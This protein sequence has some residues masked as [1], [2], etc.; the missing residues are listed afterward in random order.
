MTSRNELMIFFSRYLNCNNSLFASRILRLHNC[1]CKK[2]SQSQLYSI[3]FFHLSRI[4]CSC[5]HDSRR[6]FLFLQKFSSVLVFDFDSFSNRIRF[7][8][9]NAKN[10]FEKKIIKQIEYFFRRKTN[11]D[12][13]DFDKQNFDIDKKY[14]RKT[15][16]KKIEKTRNRR[17]QII[18]KIDFV[19]HGFVYSLINLICRDCLNWKSWLVAW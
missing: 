8:T 18:E 6:I 2:L 10:F 1:H 16:N 19:V 3:Y 13:F 9:L 15:I 5:Y 12:I 14:N 4:F 7:R 17:R 11:I